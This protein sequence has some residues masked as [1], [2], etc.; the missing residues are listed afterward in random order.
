ML[1]LRMLIKKKAKENSVSIE[2][3]QQTSLEST[4]KTEPSLNF[5]TLKE[6][7]NFKNFRQSDLWE[8]I[9]KLFYEARRPVN[10]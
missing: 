6:Y 2:T 3:F 1:L 10:S 8:W 4:R 9:L 5:P 7:D